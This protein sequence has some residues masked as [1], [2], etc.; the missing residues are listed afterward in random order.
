MSDFDVVNANNTSYDKDFVNAVTN[1]YFVYGESMFDIASYVDNDLIDDFE[2][3]GSSESRN[4]LTDA[5]ARAIINQ[6]NEVQLVENSIKEAN[7]TIR[8]RQIHILSAEVS[9]KDSTYQLNKLI[10]FYKTLSD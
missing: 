2:N 3:G 10:E 9:L 4:A 8:D 5:V 1:K 6:R 7:L